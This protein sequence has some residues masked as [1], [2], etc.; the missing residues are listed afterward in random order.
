MSDSDLGWFEVSL[1]VQDIGRSLAFYQTLGFQLVDG[2]VE[3]RNVT[4]QKGDCRIGLYQGYL[5]PPETQLIFWQGDV[6]AIARDLVGRGLRFERGPT[7]GDDGGAGALL[8]D[9][10]GHPI[11]FINMPGVLRKGP[12]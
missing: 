4:L 11:Y 8:K 7:K 6:D 1:N 3:L 2:S 10:D 5:D 12:G 9:P